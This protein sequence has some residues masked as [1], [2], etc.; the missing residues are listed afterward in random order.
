MTTFIWVILLLLGAVVLTALARRLRAPYPTFLAIGGACLAFVP[1]GPHWTLDPSLGAGTVRRAGAARC[2]LRHVAARCARQLAADR[3]PCHHRCRA[4]D[5]SPLRWSRAGSCRTCRGARRSRSAPS[6]RRPMRRRRPRSC[7]SRE[8]RIG[9]RD[10]RR[11]KPAQRCDRAARSTASRSAR[12]QPAASRSATSVGT[13]AIAVPASLV[14]GYLLG[15]I[16]LRIVAS[17]R[18]APMAIIMQFC[19]TLRRVDSRRRDRPFRHPHPGRLCH[20]DRLDGADP[21]AGAHCAFPLTPC[22]RPRSSS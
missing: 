9:S 14:A 13:F 3:Q 5:G 12:S 10:P 17:H 6:S 22:G 19:S 21:H 8:C 16:S 7:A 20:D 1:N 11:R 2:G 15:R 4:D 18:E